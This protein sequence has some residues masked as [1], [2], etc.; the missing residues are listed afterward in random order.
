ML[1]RYRAQSSMMH[2]ATMLGLALTF[3]IRQLQY[4]TKVHLS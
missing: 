2:E 3:F 1:P 4:Q